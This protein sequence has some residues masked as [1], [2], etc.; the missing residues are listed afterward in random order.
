M[1]GANEQ[2]DTRISVGYTSSEADGR[3]AV[4]KCV[5]NRRKFYAARV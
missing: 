2:I 3:A 4:T 1:M 5:E